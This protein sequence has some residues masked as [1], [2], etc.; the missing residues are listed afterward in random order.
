MPRLKG[1]VNVQIRGQ[2]W[3]LYV[4]AASEGRSKCTNQE[5]VVG[6]IRGCYV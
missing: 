5:A 1:E 3:G 2:L 6:V 4:G